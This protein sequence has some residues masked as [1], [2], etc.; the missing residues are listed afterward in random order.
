[1]KHIRFIIA[2]FAWIAAISGCEGELH[3]AKQEASVPN[4]ETDAPRPSAGR[5]PGTSI[6]IETG[7]NHVAQSD[8]FDEKAVWAG[9][10]NNDWTIYAYSFSSGEISTI[11]SAQN[12]PH[13]GIPDL[14]RLSL[15]N[16]GFLSW[17]SD[18]ADESGHAAKGFA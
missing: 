1:M 16:N 13:D 8:I 5:Y 9:G 2:A 6:T 14:A 17:T 3:P 18:E 15:S 7:H 11:D 10:N 12:H 4:R